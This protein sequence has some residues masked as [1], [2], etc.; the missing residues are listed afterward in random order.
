[1]MIE[2][3]TRP[4]QDPGTCPDSIFFFSYPSRPVPL[5]EFFLITWLDPVLN[6]SLEHRFSTRKQ[7]L[8]NPWIEMDEREK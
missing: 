8:D 1:M 4:W 6:L 7:I 3:M 5:P 2:M